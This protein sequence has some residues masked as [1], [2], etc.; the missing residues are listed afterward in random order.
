MGLWSAVE[1][2]LSGNS[3]QKSGAIDLID[4]AMEIFKKLDFNH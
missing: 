4:S 2:E 1:S 3:A